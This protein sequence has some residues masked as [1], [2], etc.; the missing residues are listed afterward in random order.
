MAICGKNQ[1][2]VIYQLMKTIIQ[3]RHSAINSLMSNYKVFSN[4][5]RLKQGPQNYKN[6]RQV[7]LMVQQQNSNH[8]CNAKLKILKWSCVRDQMF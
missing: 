5:G 2:L 6:I 3:N 8:I 4:S 7:F 1:L